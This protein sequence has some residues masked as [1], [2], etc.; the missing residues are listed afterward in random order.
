[1]A[2][3][4]VSSPISQLLHSNATPPYSL[5]NGLFLVDFVGLH[6]KSKRARRKLGASSSSPLSRAAVPQFV[7]KRASSSPVRAVLDLQRPADFASQPKVRLVPIIGSSSSSSSSS[8][9]ELLCRGRVW[10]C[11]QKAVSVTSLRERRWFWFLNRTKRKRFFGSEFP[12][13]F[14][15]C[16]GGHHGRGLATSTPGASASAFMGVA[17]APST[18]NAS[19]EATSTSSLKLNA[20]D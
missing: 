13:S 15:L 20:P 9:S 1:M 4:S 18:P 7:S 11:C 12:A 8:S 5:R 14:V 2:S 16:I 17:E 19:A 10:F 3:Q 6:C